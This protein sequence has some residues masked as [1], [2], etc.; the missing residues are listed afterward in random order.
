MYKK[1][2]ES[3]VYL[4]RKGRKEELFI[5]LQKVDPNFTYQGNEELSYVPEEDS[6]V[7][8][9]GLF[10]DKRGLSTIMFW[11]AFFS[12]LLMVYGLNTWLP[13]LMI[14]AG[15]GLNSSLGFLIILQ[16]G[17]IVGRILSRAY[18][19]NLVLKKCLFLCMPQVQLH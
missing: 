10:K 2:P 3:A 18:V 15:Y 16:G 7:P 11:T 19:I 17:A 8:I 14:E 4:V 6:K 13:K 9:V 12:C 1:L 5:N